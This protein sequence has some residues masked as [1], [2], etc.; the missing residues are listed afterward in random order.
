MPPTQLQRL[1][2]Q[3]GEHHLTRCL[4]ESPKF[5]LPTGSYRFVCELLMGHDPPCGATLEGSS[6]TWNEG[7]ER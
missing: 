5:Q 1:L 7:E 6:L 2:V 4:S 3:S